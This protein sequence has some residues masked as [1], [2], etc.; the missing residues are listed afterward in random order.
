MS[1]PN[2]ID[3]KLIGDKELMKVLAGLE[4]KLQQKTLKKVVG[5]AAQTLVRPLRNEI[6]KRTTGL[7]QGK[8]S[9]WHPSGLGKKSIGKKVGRSKRSAVYFV[10]PKGPKGDYLRD[11]WY[12]KFW[13]FGA[14]GK[15]RNMKITRF[16][17][18]NLKNTGAMMIKSIRVIMEREMKKGRK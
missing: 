2:D 5:N 1:K 12:L 7:V 9:K 15:N 14:Y 6:P 18:R 16:F 11:P 10:G 17:E 4:F 3:V 13:E 8:N